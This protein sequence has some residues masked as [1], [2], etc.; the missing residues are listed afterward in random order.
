MGESFPQLW[1]LVYSDESDH[2]NF[3]YDDETVK[4]IEI[5]TRKTEIESQ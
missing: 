4:W 5:D 1:L 2:R 3:L